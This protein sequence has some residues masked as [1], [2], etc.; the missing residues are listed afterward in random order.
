MLGNFNQPPRPEIATDVETAMFIIQRIKAEDEQKDHYIKE[1]E[2][3]LPTITDPDMK[4]T[5]SNVIKE[6]SID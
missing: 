4:E 3:L 6:Y 1:A 2:K 5:L